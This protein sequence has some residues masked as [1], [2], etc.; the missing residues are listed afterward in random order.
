[1][2]PHPLAQRPRADPSA[3][4]GRSRAQRRGAEVIRFSQIRRNALLALVACV[5]SAAV[6]GLA[7]L[8]R[9]ARAA[10][11]PT[12]TGEILTY[13]SPIELLFSHDRAQF[14]VLCQGSNEVRVLDPSTFA[15][16]K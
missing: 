12:R 8:G 4:T 6:S 7:Y 5:A 11:P 1:Q 3:A 13:A 15:E 10:V 14:F 2:D 9:P 16:I